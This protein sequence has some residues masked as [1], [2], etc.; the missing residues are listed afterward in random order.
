MKQ[1]EIK[2]Q[3]NNDNLDLTDVEWLDRFYG[4]LQDEMKQTPSKAFRIIYFLQERLPVFPDHIEQCYTCKRLYDSYSEGHHSEM[5]GRNYC[6]ES[7]EPH[8]LHEKEQRW[9]K[10]KDVPFQRWLKSVKKEQEKYFLLRG[11]EISEGY[12]RAYFSDGKTVIEA[13]NDIIT[14]T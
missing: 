14:R 2:M 9:E 8:E 12:L 5:L 13:L 6:S 1:K 10:R 4:F 7:C 3:K 11:K